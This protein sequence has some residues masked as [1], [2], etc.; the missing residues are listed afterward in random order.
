MREQQLKSF[1]IVVC[2]LFHSQFKLSYYCRP[3]FFFF[4]NMNN[5]Q[6]MYFAMAFQKVAERGLKPV[7]QVINF[8]CTNFP[9]FLWIFNGIFLL[10]KYDFN[11]Q[12]PPLENLWVHYRYLDLFSLYF[13]LAFKIIADCKFLFFLTLGKR[14]V[15]IFSCLLHIPRLLG[16]RFKIEIF[17]KLF[18]IV[19]LK[20]FVLLILKESM[21]N[22]LNKN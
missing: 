1:I 16:T 6:F 11:S 8:N 9:R 13:N 19:F 10:N 12:E 4:F 17:M 7:L 20:S 15:K 18:F 21:G 2:I 5:E 14:I 3:F 22:Y